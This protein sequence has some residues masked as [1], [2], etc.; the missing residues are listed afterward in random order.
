MHILCELNIMEV[1]KISVKLYF[2]ECI[3]KKEMC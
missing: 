3:L 2:A 1:L